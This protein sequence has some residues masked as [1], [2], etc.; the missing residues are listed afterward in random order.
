MILARQ[1]RETELESYRQRVIAADADPTNYDPNYLE[2]DGI[3]N[4]GDGFVWNKS[5]QQWVRTPTTTSVNQFLF[6]YQAR[7]TGSGNPGP[8]RIRWVGGASQILST[9]LYISHLTEDDIDL[10]QVYTLTHTGSKM[11]VQDR[12]EHRNFQR[13]IV[14]S[15]PVLVEGTNNYWQIPV[16]L[17]THGGTGTTGFSNNH[18][19]VLYAVL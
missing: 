8:G 2:K 14:S 18:A 13:W 16:T 11:I 1:E 19:L 7:T 15:T 4:D 6:K 10:D 17:E 9:H 5:R 12:D 3:D